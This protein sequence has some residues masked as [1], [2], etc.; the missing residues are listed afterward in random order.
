MNTNN[1]IKKIYKTAVY[2]TVMILF[3]F[4]RNGIAATTDKK[5]I[6]LET[7]NYTVTVIDKNTDQPLQLVSVI[8]KQNNSIVAVQSTNPFGRAVFDDIEMGI[9]S[10]SARY[11]GYETFS[12]TVSIDTTNRSYRI[13][14]S[15]TAV[16]LKEINIKGE[17]YSNVPTTIDIHSGQQLF[18]G[19]NY[20]AAPTSS[21]TQ[22]I[23]ENLAGAAKAPTGEV[24]IRGQH[25]E[26]SYLIDGIPVPLGVFG[27]LNEIVDPKVISKV[28]FL[29][30]GFPA[31]FGGQITGLMDVQTRI[32]SGK[33]HFDLSTYGGSYLTSNND[34]LG[35]RVGTLKALNLNGQ[36]FSVSDHLGKL[37]YF[38]EAS[39]EETDRRIDQPV[40]QLFHDHG[41]DYFT[42]GKL[43]YLLNENDYLTANINYSRTVT[44]VPYDPV[45]GYLSDQQNSYN[46]FQT[47]SFFHVIS[48]E[49]DHES[50]LFVGGFAR[51]GG[52]DYIPS[53]YDN[54]STFLG[55]DTVNGYVIEQNRNFTTLGLRTKYDNR[56]S[57]HFMYA[58][59]LSYSKTFGTENFRFFNSDGDKLIN[60]S[61][62]DGY[63]LGVFAQTEYHPYEWTKLDLG[64]RYDIHNAP[65]FSKNLTQLSPRIK[66]YVFLDD[67]NV[68]TISY[69]RLFMPINIENLGAVATQF[70][71][72]TT[73][74]YPEKDNLYEIAY[75]RNWKNGFNSKLA[76]FY[77]ESSPGLDDQT[78]GSSTIRVSVNINRI[79][80]RGIELAL[81]YNEQDFPLSG[82]LNGSIIHAFGTGPVE[83]GFLPPDSSTAPFDLD[84]DLRLT[85]VIGL[86]YQTG[87]WFLNMSANYTSGLANGIDGYEFKTGLFDFNTG[88]HTAPAWILNLSAGYT[89][90]VSD[91]H[92]LEPSIYINNILDHAH[93]IKG[94]FFSGASFEARRN[95][96]VKLTYH[97]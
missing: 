72:V 89:F 9:Y 3:L 5:E 84:H 88:A 24:H 22:L 52:L 77:K 53:V 81:T 60:S 78:L 14:L 17:K 76:G 46:G 54:N 7:I 95:I 18:E 33:F 43:D 15:E 47:L 45:E 23:Q 87:D 51:E 31:E 37:G 96:M 82:Y 32:P 12:D 57:H 16:E 91:G 69:D 67:Y 10:I 34:T 26:F 71:N 66:W 4:S 63:D 11:I 85:S 55:T 75:L 48:H 2:L 19:E 73:P 97:F 83:G 94:A 39:R 20:H 36:S 13:K 59:G 8:L 28:S 68:F 93:L 58:A 70:G 56:T 21:M 41:F 49:T 29:T 90:Y 61:D 27:G 35:S 50:N 62:F 1:I 6:Q 40:Q 79:I 74:T 80:V 64:L 44:Q 86:N 30:A 65:S 42:Y 25:G 38:I 92:T